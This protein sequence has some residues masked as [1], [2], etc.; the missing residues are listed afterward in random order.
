MG[1]F[2]LRFALL[3]RAG[4]R[5]TTQVVVQGR[6]RIDEHQRERDGF[7]RPQ[8]GATI[9]AFERYAVIAKYY[10]TVTGTAELRRRQP[11]HRGSG[12]PYA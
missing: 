10:I 4:D 8:W 3:G 7:D 5:W 1:R 6:G 12:N 2:F 11:I 9:R